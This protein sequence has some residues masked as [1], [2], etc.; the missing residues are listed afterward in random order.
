MR[1]ILS[2]LAIVVL[3]LAASCSKKIT[4]ETSDNEKYYADEKL[5]KI[6]QLQDRRET[7]SLIPYLKAKKEIYRTRTAVA[8]GTIRD[9]RALPYLFLML[10]TDN[11]LLPRVAAAWAIGQ[12]GDESAVPDLLKASSLELN[13]NVLAEIMEAIGKCANAEAIDFLRKFDNSDATL[14]AGHAAGMFRSMFKTGMDSVLIQRAFTYLMDDRDGRADFYAAHYLAR[15]KSEFD[16]ET[17]IKLLEVLLASPNSETKCAIISCLGYS[18]LNQLPIQEIIKNASDVSEKIETIKLITSIRNPAFDRRKMFAEAIENWATDNDGVDFKLRGYEFAIA[19]GTGELFNTDMKYPP[20]QSMSNN[21]LIVL[22]HGML[23]NRDD[24]KINDHLK[25]I[26]NSGDLTIYEMA[27]AI[28]AVA[29]SRSNYNWIRSTLLNE[30]LHSVVR[31]HALDALLKMDL[32]ACKCEYEY[33][34]YFTLIDYGLRSGDMALQSLASI[35]ITSDKFRNPYTPSDLSSLIQLLDSVIASKDLPR[36]TETWFDLQKAHSVLTGKPFNFTNPTFNHPVNWEEVLAI[37]ENQ[38]VRI[39]TTKG[40]IVLRCF[41]KYAPGSVWNFL[42]LVD[43]GFYDGKNFHRVVPNFVI[44]GGCPRGDGW[45]ALNWSQR[46]ELSPKLPFN[47]GSVGLASV[48]PDT[49]G[50]QFFITHLPAP[51][52]DGRYSVFATVID[53]M[54]VV[55]KISVGDKIIKIA[56]E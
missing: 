20:V 42:K 31:Y 13:Y 24:K 38:K 4:D 8:H 21:E 27:R 25:G 52:L 51:H 36:E 45:G 32:S 28:D 46:S 9:P 26:F 48:G 35:A 50:V 55:N 14:Q 1:K 15:S 22:S 2:F 11:E 3:F 49:E 40:E 41:V 17:I 56:R 30:S 33:S 18:R 43:E 37:P 7:D 6:A 16:Q 5:M 23:L 12:I 29:T 19:A 47:E 54:D 53:G 10:Q 34:D 44:Q 39:S